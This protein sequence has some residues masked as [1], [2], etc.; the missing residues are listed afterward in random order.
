MLYRIRY[1]TISPLGSVGGHQCSRTVDGVRE[2]RRRSDGGVEGPGVQ[3]RRWGEAGS[4]RAPALGA[5][6]RQN[7][8]IWPLFFLLHW[9][10]PQTT[11]QNKIWSLLGEFLKNDW[12]GGLYHCAPLPETLSYSLEQSS[13]NFHTQIP[14]RVEETVWYSRKLEAELKNF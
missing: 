14:P 3:G 10:K 8:G 12:R 6:V 4:L 9:N 1:S 2:L 5:A 7:R 13:L 11:K